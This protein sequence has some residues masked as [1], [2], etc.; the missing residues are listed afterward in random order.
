[1]D[2]IKGVCVCVC[3]RVSVGEMLAFWLSTL[4]SLVHTPTHSL[5]ETI[6]HDTGHPHTHT[7]TLYHT[8]TQKTARVHTQTHTNIY[9]YH[10]R[11]SPAI[12][13]LFRHLSQ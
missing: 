10:E 3:E 7:H 6:G 5:S 11:T 4:Q 9:G 13:P 2:S 8:L 1:M 12:V